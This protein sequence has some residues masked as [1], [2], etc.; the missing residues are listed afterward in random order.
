MNFTLWLEN[1]EEYLKSKEFGIG[2]ANKFKQSQIDVD[3][4]IVIDWRQSEIDHTNKRI[5][6]DYQILNIDNKLVKSGKINYYNLPYDC[7]YFIIYELAKREEI[8]HPA[9]LLL[10]DGQF[11]GSGVAQPQIDMAL[12]KKYWSL[13]NQ[14]LNA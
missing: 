2:L 8:Y 4:E 10:I 3:G 14:W 11:S 1:D 13:V 5:F 7:V 6:V 9:N 12:V